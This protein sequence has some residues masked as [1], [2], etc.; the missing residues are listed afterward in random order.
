MKTLLLLVGAAALGYY[1]ARHHLAVKVQAPTSSMAPAN[2]TDGTA[3]LPGDGNF[4][5]T[6]DPN[7]TL[8][9]PGMATGCGCGGAQSAK[10]ATV[11]LAWD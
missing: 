10:S 9:A 8:G 4:A 3:T 2:T 11:S 7:P 6:D 1:V 5:G